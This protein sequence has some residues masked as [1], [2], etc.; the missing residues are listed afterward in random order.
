MRELQ[1]AILKADLEAFNICV[2]AIVCQPVPGTLD[3]CCVF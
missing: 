1:A 2:D 3:A